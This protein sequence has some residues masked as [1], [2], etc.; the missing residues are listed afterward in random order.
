M[1]K[2]IQKARNALFPKKMKSLFLDDQSDSSGK[3]KRLFELFVPQKV[4]YLLNQASTKD[5]DI[6]NTSVLDT[7]LTEAG[8]MLRKKNKRLKLGYADAQDLAI[9]L[10]ND[11]YLVKKNNRQLPLLVRSQSSVTSGPHTYASPYAASLSS[12][13]LTRP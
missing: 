9:S 1:R 3:S 2:L 4:T 10:F 5:R 8:K 12:Q 11:N 6:P 13:G 7:Y